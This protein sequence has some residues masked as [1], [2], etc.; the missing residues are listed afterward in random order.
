MQ[1]Q[2]PSLIDGIRNAGLLVG[3][4]G[5]TSSL[6]SLVT[7][8]SVPQTPVDASLSQGAVVFLDR[9]AQGVDFL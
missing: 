1:V 5:E 8:S 3:V 2:V 6:E 7:A 9:S 4:Y